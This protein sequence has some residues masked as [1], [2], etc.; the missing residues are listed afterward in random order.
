MQGISIYVWTEQEIKLTSS[1]N[2]GGVV[3]RVRALLSV[4]S[5]FFLVHRQQKGISPSPIAGQD[6][7]A[8]NNFLVVK[9]SL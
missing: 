4:W 3:G 5:S 6:E 1:F 9:V 2:E 7:G 8:S